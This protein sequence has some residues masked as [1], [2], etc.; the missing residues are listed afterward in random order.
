VEKVGNIS[1]TPLAR[2]MAHAEGI[3]LSALTGT[4]VGGRITKEDV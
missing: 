1:A 4:G 3:D 2:K